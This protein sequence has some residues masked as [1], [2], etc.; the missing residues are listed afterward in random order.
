MD[1][2]TML[3]TLT[4][5]RATWEALLSQIHEDQMVQPGVAGKWSV[6]DIIAHVT[7]SETE[8][9]PTLRTHVLGGSDLWRLPADER[10]ELNYQQNKDRPLHDIVN[11]E[12]QAFAE[13]LAGVLSLSDEDL[14]DPQRF[15]NMPPDWIP[16]QLI[17]GITFRHYQDHMPAI[18]EWLAGLPLCGER[19]A[20]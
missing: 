6:K 2:A 8:L 1:K 14:N 11:A 7:W 18:G 19:R 16:W 3:K 17:A 12:R 5:T 10:N 13:V 9:A 20:A 4:E 15:Q